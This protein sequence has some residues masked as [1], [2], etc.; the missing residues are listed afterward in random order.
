VLLE[1]HEVESSAFE[2]GRI[3]QSHPRVSPRETES[4]QSLVTSPA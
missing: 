3:G 2:I 4:K 1:R